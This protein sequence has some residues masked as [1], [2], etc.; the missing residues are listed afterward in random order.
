MLGTSARLLRLLSLL[1]ARRSW[2]GA[3]LAA[4]LE[5][6]DRTLRR[7]V[8]RL[9]SLGYP[10]G[11]TSGVAGGYRLGAGAALPP[12]LLAD[13]EAL[14]VSLGLRSA[15]SGNVSGMEEAALRAL[16]KLDQVLP[17][18]LRKRMRSLHAAVA[19]SLSFGPRVDADLLMALATG[20]QARETLA[21]GYRDVRGRDTEREVEPQGLVHSGPYWYL[22]AWDLSRQDFRTFRVDRITT[23]ARAGRRF[24]PRPVPGGDLARYVSRAI[25]SDAYPHRARIVLHAPRAQMARA[26]SPSSG[27]LTELDAERC[28]LEAGGARLD[29]LAIHIAMLGVEYEVLEPPELLEVM[30]RLAATLKRGVTRSAKRKRE[31]GR[32][33]TKT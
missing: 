11:A 27:V 31:S 8:E 29:S 5:V 24:T 9:R 23:R 26:I 28:L 32:R 30:S 20:A 21:F 33:A 1:Q 18:R 4:E 3:D 16:T 25:S 10:V 14:A 17:A 12:L 7:D 13:D 22:V 6:T 15:A 2:S 19:P